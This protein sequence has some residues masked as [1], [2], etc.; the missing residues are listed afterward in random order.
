MSILAN[1]FPLVPNAELR[2]FEKPSRQLLNFRDVLAR[3]PSRFHPIRR[4]G[5]RRPVFRVRV[6]ERDAFLRQNDSARPR[7][8]PC[9]RRNRYAKHSPRRHLRANWRFRSSLSDR[10]R[11]SAFQMNWK[12][13]HVDFNFYVFYFYRKAQNT[14]VIKD[15]IYFK[16]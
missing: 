2:V 12:G 9:E 6:R 16:R 13:L 11:K 8:S 3:L 5:N 1:L 15:C 14:L 7:A 4:R 10:L